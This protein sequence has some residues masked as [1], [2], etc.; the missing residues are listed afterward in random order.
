MGFIDFVF[1]CF[2]NKACLLLI[3]FWQISVGFVLFLFCFVLS[4]CKKLIVYSINKDSSMFF[5]VVLNSS[6]E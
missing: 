5:D 1:L 4:M 6:W 2:L 3:C